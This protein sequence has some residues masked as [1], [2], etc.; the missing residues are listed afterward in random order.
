MAL[1][2]ECMQPIVLIPKSMK[3]IGVVPETKN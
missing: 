3:L 1:V 2:P